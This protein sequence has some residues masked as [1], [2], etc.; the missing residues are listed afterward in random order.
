MISGLA[1]SLLGFGDDTGCVTS[2]T[3]LFLQSSEWKA[4]PRVRDA[5]KR[6]KWAFFSSKN[7]VHSK[8]HDFISSLLCVLKSTAEPHM[9]SGIAPHSSDLYPTVTLTCAVELQP[10]SSTI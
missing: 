3:T 2:L 1:G 6:R 7:R 9:S 4:L 8:L 5:M 10:Y